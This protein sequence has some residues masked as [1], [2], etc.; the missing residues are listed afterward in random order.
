MK[1]LSAVVLI[2]LALSFVH[3]AAHTGA[4]VAL[5]P[6]GTAFVYIVILAGPLVGLAVAARW[7]L[8]GSAI[9][10]LTMAGSLVFG[11]I[12]HFIIQG[13]DHVAHVA[14]AWRPLFASTAA[15]LALVEAAGTAIGVRGALRV[16]RGP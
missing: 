4:A 5:D 15:L 16:R 13:T 7:P 14:D 12:N 2:H 11:L 1:A 3:G 8:A 10:A 9:V 6:A